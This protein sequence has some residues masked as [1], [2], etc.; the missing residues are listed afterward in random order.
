MTPTVVGLGRE[1]GAGDELPR[2]ADGISHY[3]D[4]VFLGAEL[5]M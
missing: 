1:L 2:H 4:R 3:C 5:L